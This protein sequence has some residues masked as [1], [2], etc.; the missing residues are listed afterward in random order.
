MQRGW[1][2]GLKTFVH[3]GVSAPTSGDAE[4]HSPVAV[5]GGPWRKAGLCGEC[6]TTFRPEEV[7]E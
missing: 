4:H 2:R 5:R 6:I 3:V 7:V 1:V